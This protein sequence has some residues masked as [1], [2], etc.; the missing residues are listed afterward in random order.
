MTK[1][2]ESDFRQ[3]YVSL[4]RIN[5]YMSTARIRRDAENKNSALSYEEY[6]EMA[7]ENIQQEAKNGLH[8]VRL[9]KGVIFI[10]PSSGPPLG[11]M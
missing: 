6:L 9:P 1:K 4:R 11:A 5:R 8:G 2:E 10:T 7:Y 3:M